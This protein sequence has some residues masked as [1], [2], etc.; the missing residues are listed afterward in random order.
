MDTI[1]V[2]PKPAPLASPKLVK[3]AKGAI[4]PSSQM[5]HV[6]YG[7]EHMRELL[8]NARK[9]TLHNYKTIL[10]NI[11]ERPSIIAQ[12]YKNDGRPVV[13]LR[14]LYLCLQCPSIL[15]EADRDSHIESKLHCF[16][17]ESREGYIYC[18]HCQ[19]FIYDPELEKRRLQKATSTVAIAKISSMIPSWRRGGCRRLH[20]LWPLPR[21]HL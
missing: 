16:S 8:E 15:T 10:Q 9:H 17:V 19:D 12:T 14:P 11:H 7:C 4:V 1:T 6:E 18:G 3:N 21:F 5:A 2:T 13:S 20:L